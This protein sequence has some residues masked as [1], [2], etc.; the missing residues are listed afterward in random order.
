MRAIAVIPA[1]WQSSR[2][3]GKPLADLN[4]RI[5]IRLVY[6]KVV[7]SS[8]FAEVIVATDDE[9]IRQA[10]EVFGGKVEM[11][12][13]DH[14]SGTDRVA[15]VCRRHEFDIVVNVQGDEPMIA[16][17]PLKDLVKA[18]EDKEVM[19][20]SLMNRLTDNIDNP[21]QV[22]VVIDRNGDALYFSR[23]VI[24]YE[25]DNEQTA[26]YWGHIGVYAFRKE[27]LETFVKLPE[28]KLEKVEKLEQLR[29]LENGYKIRM[30]ATEYQ[31]KGIDTPEDLVQL[32]KYMK[33]R[34]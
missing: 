34:G 2:F 7:A 11:T 1:R 24:P 17:Q 33:R 4:G 16:T 13:T 14:R 23:A 26:E 31:G 28:S 27:M 21:N 6:E 3:P 30:I 19:V 32:M 9:R 29:L 5:I 15:E 12:R 25:R 10:V 20:A 18:F 22:K 8:I